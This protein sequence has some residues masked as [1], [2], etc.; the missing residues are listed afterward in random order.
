MVIVAV[1]NGVNP[2]GVLAIA[3]EAKAFGKEY[4]SQVAGSEQ[5]ADYSNAARHAYWQAVV[6]YNYGREVAQRIGDIHEQGN[7]DLGWAARQ[8]SWIDSFNNDVARRIAEDALA[9]GPTEEE[10]INELLD[11]IVD[12]RLIVD[13]KDRR[14]P[15]ELRDSDGDGV[16][17]S[18]DCETPD[19]AQPVM[20]PGSDIPIPRQDVN[21]S[22]SIDM[23]DV[24]ILANAIGTQSPDKDQDGDCLILSSDVISVLQAI[25]D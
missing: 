9:R 12:G 11:A 21:A 13:K 23:E 5:K 24:A 17:D 19:G 2:G 1:E 20:Y 15:P 16:P 14:I 10:L 18:L 6:T 7:D 8:D 25:D 22:G 3:V 4:A